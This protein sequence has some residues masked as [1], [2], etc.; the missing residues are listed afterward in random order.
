MDRGL[1]R[2]PTGAA[3]GFQ[4]E[5]HMTPPDP[6]PAVDSDSRPTLETPTPVR[7]RLRT[8]ASSPFLT[9]G[10]GLQQGWRTAQPDPLHGRCTARSGRSPEVR[11]A[12]R[13]CTTLAQCAFGPLHGRGTA[14][15]QSMRCS[16]GALQVGWCLALSGN[17]AVTLQCTANTLRRQYISRFRSA[18]CVVGTS[19][20]MVHLISRCSALLAHFT[21]DVWH[22]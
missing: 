3:S 5:S 8:L 1:R 11:T 10:R 9:G 17:C 18:H 16:A 19:K 2:T 12:R 13:H 22:S 20:S 14:R 4:L 6:R 7:A 15:L 21:G